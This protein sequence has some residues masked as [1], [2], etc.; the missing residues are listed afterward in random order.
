MSTPSIH[1]YKKSIKYGGFWIRVAA[2]II[3]YIVHLIPNMLFAFLQRELTQAATAEIDQMTQ[4]F[5]I[6]LNSVIVDWIYFAAL[7]SSGWQ[8][9]IGKKVVGLKV[10]DENGRRIS[11]GR[12]T[13]RY[14]ASM[15]S[16]VIFCIG[17][18][19]VGWTSRKRGLHDSMAGTFVIYDENTIK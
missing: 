1:E 12:A 16:A 9:T 13:G 10:V 2:I 7:Q 4:E 18:M 14:F 3:D 11:F 15:I 5:S 8:A 17:Y 6:F 19:M